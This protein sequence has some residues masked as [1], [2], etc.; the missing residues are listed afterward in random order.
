MQD[1][2]QESR[3][4]VLLVV[5]GPAGIGKTT[6][7]Q[8]LETRHGPHLQRVVTATSRPPRAGE[9]DGVDY[10][11]FPPEVFEA[12]IEGE[13]FY[14][15]AL[16]HGRHYG[17]LKT[18]I[19]EPLEQGSD[20]LL[21]IDVQGA[22][23][24]R[25]AAESDPA[26]QGRFVSIFIRPNNLEQIEKRLRS[27]AKDSEEE[28]ARRLQTAERE[29]PCWKTFTYAFVSNTRRHDFGALNAIYLSETMRVARLLQQST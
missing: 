15:H 7:C 16:V 27:R 13:A 19:R 23:T 6:V 18:A 21:N 14:E 26:L 9:K 24:F 25:L 17:V 29:I 22:E 20:L 3:R 28:I 10:H 4:G 8:Q 5:S 2:P 1:S 11:F 12:K